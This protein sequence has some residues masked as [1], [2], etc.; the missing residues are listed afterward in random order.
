MLCVL[1]LRL[2]AIQALNI[3]APAPARSIVH[4]E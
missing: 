4:L 1:F 3:V 2:V